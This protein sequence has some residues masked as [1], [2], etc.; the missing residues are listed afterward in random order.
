MKKLRNALKTQIN[1]LLGQV[2]IYFSAPKNTQ[3]L[4]NEILERKKIK[5]LSYSDLDITDL[6]FDTLNL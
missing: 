3:R 2:Y 5:H 4:K 6:L 1:G